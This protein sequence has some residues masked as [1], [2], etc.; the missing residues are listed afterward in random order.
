MVIGRQ[1]RTPMLEVIVINLFIIFLGCFKYDD[2]LN[3]KVVFIGRY[4]E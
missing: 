1:K 2:Q 3:G 4:V